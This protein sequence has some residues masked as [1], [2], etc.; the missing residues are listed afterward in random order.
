VH[1]YFS[2]LGLPPGTPPAIVR[3]ASA[4][5]VDAVHPDFRPAPAPTLLDAAGL[6][7]ADKQGAPADLAVN[8]IEMAALVDGMEAAFFRSRR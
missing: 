2:I 3:R 4:R 5:R 1:D 7:V 6:P 8:F